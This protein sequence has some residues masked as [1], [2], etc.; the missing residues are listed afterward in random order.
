[1]IIKSALNNDQ[2]PKTYLVYRDLNEM[3]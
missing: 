3:V 1:M 2:V